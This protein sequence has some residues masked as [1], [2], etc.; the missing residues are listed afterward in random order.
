MIP[1]NGETWPATAGEP[2]QLPRRLRGIGRRRT[3][4]A[5]AVQLLI[6]DLGISRCEL[7]RRTG[8]SQSS[9]SDFLL[10]RHVMSR[11][12]ADRLL[13]WLWEFEATTEVVAEYRSA[14]GET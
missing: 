14:G 2:I 12:H 3:R 1:A 5:R 10:G 13:Q 11:A 8:L 6:D 9:V 7:A 4:L